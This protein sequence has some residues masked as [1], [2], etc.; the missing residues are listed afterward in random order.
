MAVHISSN[1]EGIESGIVDVDKDY[2]VIGFS[3]IHQ[4]NV[5]G[6]H[7]YVAYFPNQHLDEDICA[8]CGALMV[9]NGAQGD[10]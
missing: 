1:K 2:T 3:N 8:P 10:E 5:V 7:A 9:M 4:P 6:V